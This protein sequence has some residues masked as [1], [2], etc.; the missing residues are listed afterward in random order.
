[1]QHFGF[2]FLTV[3]FQAAEQDSFLDNFKHG[4]A[5][6][7]IV[8]QYFNNKRAYMKG[9]K[10]PDSGINKR[11]RKLAKRRAKERAKRD[12]KAGATAPKDN[13]NHEVSGN[14]HSTGGLDEPILASD[15]R[16]DVVDDDDDEK[17]SVASGSGDEGEASDDDVDEE[18]GEGTDS[19]SGSEF[20]SNDGSDDDDLGTDQGG[21]EDDDEDDDAE[22]TGMDFE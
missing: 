5:T 16:A 2:P 12:K 8:S 17:A 3:V 13:D 7:S 22:S 9:K 10:M 15:D 1:M 21:S 6:L 19:G 11:R 20:G 18:S 14:D 4:W